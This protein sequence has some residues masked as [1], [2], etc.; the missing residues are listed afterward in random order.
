MLHPVAV[1]HR[2]GSSR[3]S[4][5]PVHSQIPNARS[6]EPW[7]ATDPLAG[8]LPE[9]SSL[10]RSPASEG[11]ARRRA[12]ALALSLQGYLVS[13]GQTDSATLYERV[14]STLGQP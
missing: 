1:G 9:P 4:G 14:A 11:A 12:H 13:E 10:S 7:Q 6:R 8:D 2:S 3:R 5:K